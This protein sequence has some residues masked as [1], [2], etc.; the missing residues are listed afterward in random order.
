MAEKKDMAT[1]MGEEEEALLRD[2]EEESLKVGEEELLASPAI[3]T[4]EARGLDME[5]GEA[6]PY[7]EE[8]EGEEE[9]G[10]KE[11]KE[12]ELEEGEWMEE[13]AI[14]GRNSGRSNV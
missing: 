11:G 3:Q 12:N 5:E 6:T 14:L 8:S 10:R 2:G 1:E 9:G 13:G 7:E 4:Q